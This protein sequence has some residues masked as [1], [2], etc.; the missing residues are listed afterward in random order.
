VV[1]E[2]TRFLVTG[3][4]GQLATALAHAATG[5]VR[6]VG[7]PDFD[8]ERLDSVRTLFADGVP[9]VLINAAAWTAVD[10]AES[11][12][13]AARRANAEGP[14][15][16]A[17]LCNRH[18]ARF[19]HIS[20]DY[21]FDGA[22]GAP[23]LETDPT[24]PT[25]VY[26]ATKLEGEQDVLAELPGAVIL[27]TAWVYAETGRNFVRT[28][29][30]AARKTSQLRVV[31]D[32][33]GCPTNADDLAQAVLAV[34]RRLAAP[35]PPPGG[36][37][38]CAGSGETSWYEFARAIFAAAGPLGWPVP[39]V[40][41]IATADWPTPARRPADSRLD[42]G[43]VATTFGVRLPPWQPSLQRAVSAICAAEAVA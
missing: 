32:Q 25:G 29:L 22:K 24:C 34:A 26:G 4:T 13:E 30:A 37:Y 21:V 40:Q 38:H 14:A 27:R 35:P 1:R 5:E 19:I 43:K 10:A 15:A 36:I 2:V 41:P 23:Y 39:E 7:R 6:V 28:M 3:G 17:A 16:L 11:S 8:L 18:G 9:A 42:C 33:V 31:A 20:T 12:P